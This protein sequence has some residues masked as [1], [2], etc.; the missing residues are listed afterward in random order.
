MENKENVKTYYDNY[1][2]RQRNQGITPRHRFILKRLKQYGL[3]SNSKVLE[4]GSGIGT[5][6]ELIVK[7]VKN[8]YFL[9]CDISERSIE[10]C[11]AELKHSYTDFLVTDMSN[12]KSDIQ[13]DFIVFPDVLEHIPESEH[14]LIFQNISKCIHED[15]I[16]VINI[17]E[18]KYLNWVRH[19][20]PELLQI[21]D[22][23]LSMQDLMNN[24]Y[25]AG[26]FLEEILPYAI[27][28]NVPNYL[29]IIFSRKAELSEMKMKGGF[30]KLWDNLKYRFL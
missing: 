27:H 29:S 5:L 8:G 17:P 16:V 7:E 2:G 15:S 26:F 22:Q 18:P 6:S 3:K 20:R 14:A 13:F 4:I 11:N 21:I 23:S 24:T 1:V 30:G 28:T 10:V 9:G 12:F 25:S 19:K